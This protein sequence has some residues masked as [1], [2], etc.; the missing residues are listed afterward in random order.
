[1][2][3]L[4]QLAP[5]VEVYS[6]DEA[7]LD[8]SG[9]EQAVSLT[10]LGLSIRQTIQDWIGMTVCVGIAPSKTLAKLANHAAKKWHKTAGV[11]D[12]TSDRAPA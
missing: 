1:M 9:V 4:E 11:V 12:L 10:E 5:A 6:I 8:L 7:F 2:A 3:T